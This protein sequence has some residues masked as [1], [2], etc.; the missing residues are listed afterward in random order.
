MPTAPTAAQSEASRQNGACSV[1]PVSDAGKARA[2]LNAVRHGLCGRTFF[3]LADED[4]AA[5]AE[6]E[7]EW[8]AAW[9]PR[10]VHEHEAALAAIRAMW[11]ETRAD[12]LEVLALED[13][14]AA[15]RLADD[16]ER[17]LA[18]DR[19][20]RALNALLRYKARLEREQR[21]AREALG[22]LR[23]RRLA[24][25]R[26]PAL[27]ESPAAGP[28]MPTPREPEAAPSATAPLAPEAA[29]AAT[30]PSAEVRAHAAMPD[31][32]E[33]VGR[34]RHQRRAFAAMERRR[35]A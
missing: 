3:L 26:A 21:L 1:G 27:P 29:P 25:P 33:P 2:A 23:S 8:L 4:P 15:D 34:N 10:D 24:P 14:F 6:H 16:A 32:P 30:A 11:R 9:R 20:L 18:K 35:A 22:A 13:L 5:F 17:A 19:A 7:A 31:E 12:R 28:A